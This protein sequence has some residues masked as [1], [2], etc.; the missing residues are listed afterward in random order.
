MIMK[1]TENAMPTIKSSEVV[2][3]YLATNTAQVVGVNYRFRRSTNFLSGVQ[4]TG[5]NTASNEDEW[6][7]VEMQSTVVYSKLQGEV[8]EKCV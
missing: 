1:D 7:K 6:M 2:S 4:G 3:I 8:R 5:D